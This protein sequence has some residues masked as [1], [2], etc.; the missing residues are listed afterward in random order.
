VQQEYQQFDCWYRE[1]KISPPVVRPEKR[2][3]YKTHACGEDEVVNLSYPLMVI[4][5]LPQA[6]K[7][8][9]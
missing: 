4:V 6:S 8:K 5:V 1:T 3:A 2:Q 9:T 7:V